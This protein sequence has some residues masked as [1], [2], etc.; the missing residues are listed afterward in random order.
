VS[1]NQAGLT[2]GTYV[3]QVTVTAP[4]ATG[5]PKTVV[6]RFVV[7]SE[8]ALVVQPPSLVFTMVKGGSN[9]EPQTLDI[10]FSGSGNVTWNAVSSASWVDLSAT[11]GTTPSQSE[12]SVD[13]TGFNAGTYTGLIT[14]SSTPGTAGS[15]RFVPV[16]LVVQMPAGANCEP[17]YWYCEPFDALTQGDLGGQAGWE[18]PSPSNWSPQVAPDPRDVGKAMLL[19][20]FPGKLANSLRNVSAQSIDDG[21]E[22]SMQVMTTGVPSDAKQVGKVEFFTD[23]GAAW[24]KTRRTFGALRFGR[25]LY[26][27]WGPNVYQVLVNNMQP[28][29]WYHVRVEYANGK[30][31][32]YV[33]GLL[34][35]STPNPLLPG[36]KMEAFAVTGW[37]YPGSAYVDL[38]EG[39]PLTTGLVVEPLTLQFRTSASRPDQPRPQ[40]AKARQVRSTKS[41]PSPEARVEDLRRKQP[42][43]FEANHG[44]ADSRVRFLARG[45]NHELL[46]TADEAALRLKQQASGGDAT[47]TALLKMRLQGGN[48]SPEIEGRELLPGRTNY[49][50][51]RDPSKW[52]TGVPHYAQVAY[53][54]VYPGIDLVFHGRQ[55]QLE[56]DLVVSPHADPSSIRLSFD[57]ASAMRVGPEGDL[58]LETPLGEVRQLKPVIYQEAE[59]E[60]RP[61]AGGYVLDGKEVGFRLAAYDPGLP[62]VIDPV[63]SYATF[64]GGDGVDRAFAIDIDEDQNIYVA[65]T[66]DSID[67]PTVAAY[68]G[69]IGST[70][71]AFVTKFAAD[72]SHLIY[73][74]FLGGAGGDSQALGLAV[75]VEGNAFVTGSTSSTVF[76][77]VAP[78]QEAYGGGA[79]DAFIT[80]LDPAGLP[81]L[82]TYV[83]GSGT[84]VGKG[85]A[86]NASWPG[87]PFIVGDTDSPSM[88]GLLP[89]P[90]NGGVP[91]GADVFVY[92]VP[93][94]QGSHHV[95]L[96][97]LNGS[98]LDQAAGIAMD[99]D[100]VYVTGTTFSSPNANPTLN[101]FPASP[102]AYQSPESG[103]GDVFVAKLDN[104]WGTL[105]YSAFLA[106]QEGEGAVGIALDPNCPTACTPYVVGH[107]V[108]LGFPG[109]GPPGFVFRLDAAGTDLVQTTTIG[110]LDHTFFVRAIDVDGEGNSY[111]TG[112]ASQTGLGGCAT[113]GSYDSGAFVIK[114]AP[115][116]TP[117]GCSLISGAGIEG[118]GIAVDPS[119]DAFV[120]GET[121]ASDQLPV[122]AF[123]TTPNAF[124]F[125]LGGPTDAFVAKLTEPAGTPNRIQFSAEAYTV[126]EEAGLAVI[127]VTRQGDTSLEATVHYATTDGTATQAEDY[128]ATSGVLT[129]APMDTMGVIIVPIVADSA[130]EDDETINLSLGNT[131]G[132]AVLGSPAT[133]TLTI[134]DDDGPTRKLR[135]RDRVLPVG[136]NWTAQIDV[137]WLTLSAMSG[138]GPSLVTVSI[139]GAGADMPPGVYLGNI[140]VN[141][142]T[143]NSPQIVNVIWTVE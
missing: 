79:S 91:I 27:Q 132:G 96:V 33:D 32:A 108:S 41:R 36:H 60:R 54:G 82:S 40:P 12:V 21:F 99:Q 104:W 118:R 130:A 72:G 125:T 77:L 44:Q 138:T 10:V 6:V 127:V 85:I 92:A 95:Y 52:Q 66:T 31:N 134:F 78:Q 17:G 126:D 120:A 116:G 103:S 39:R 25:T 135:I 83:G 8:P 106:S 117:L 110:E 64:L 22:L 58:I 86:V 15:P 142:N 34:R 9:P 98:Q 131:S 68:Q 97:Y 65:G 114:M 140:V 1:V 62:L 63:L 128:E 101:P 47:R 37:D 129:F 46:L 53:R 107:T 18:P 71:D 13:G 26:L 115:E 50:I 7:T 141:G 42:L 14:V 23:A 94:S 48:A 121:G 45:R 87:R 5:S 133:A 75:D 100:S 70:V 19:D 81:L 55:H 122:G 30:V 74:T 109:G 137:P 136:P 102:G 4:G 43:S 80:E 24:G 2:V 11:A 3:G 73:S 76:P 88:A 112:H 143:G 28:D 59:G 20:P 57:G 113:F 49:L 123:P 84:D 93:P 90:I 124:D 119:G 16:Q 61:I 35:Y 105:H 67:F 69:T 38:I 56:Y 111:V 29:R 89:A 51:G 139:G